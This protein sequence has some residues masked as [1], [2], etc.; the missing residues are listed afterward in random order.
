[1]N[2]LIAILAAG[3]SR[4]FGSDKLAQPCAG[5][6]VGRWALNAAMATGLPVVWIAGETAPDHVAATCEVTV[7]VDAAQGIAT[8]VGVAA[9]IA[10]ERGHD[11]LLIMLADM[12]LV[13][14]ELLRRLVELGAPAACRHPDGRPGVPALL[15]A[16]AF[17]LLRG[18]TGDRG[19]GSVLGKLP[20]LRTIDCKPG[21][22]LDVD[23]PSDLT[24]AIRL[25]QRSVERINS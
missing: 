8:S 22:L 7:N 23:S 10:A 15:P 25:L 14:P 11:S 12:P 3:R 9:R 2:P 18:L 19:A 4:R 16:S 17:P 6:P 1:V 5:K 24:E 13:G 21:E 20:Q